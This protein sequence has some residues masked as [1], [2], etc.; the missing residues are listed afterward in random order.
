MRKNP[1]SQSGFL[2]PR[3]LLAFALCSVGLFLAIFSLAATPQAGSNNIVN[4][5]ELFTELSPHQDLPSPVSTGPVQLRPSASSADLQ[6]IVSTHPGSQTGSAGSNSLHLA[7]SR[8][9]ATRRTSPM[10][11]R[12]A[13]LSFLAV[14]FARAPV[15]FRSTTP[16]PSTGPL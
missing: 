5:T 16:G 3:V 6:S 10:T 1:N 2:N 15:V 14:S 4:V 12:V 7:P 9:A 13:C 11:R 8:S